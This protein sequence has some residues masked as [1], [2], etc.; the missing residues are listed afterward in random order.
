MTLE[1][2]EILGVTGASGA[3]MSTLIKAIMLL[4][5][6]QAGQVLIKGQHHG[7]ASARAHIAYLPE[8]VR[9]PGHLT[10]HDFIA[11]TRTVQPGEAAPVDIGALATDLDLKPALV[12]LP[13][14][15]YAKDEVQKL[16]LV[17]LLATGRPILLLDRPM[18]DLEPSARAGLRHRLRRHADDG[19][20]VLIGSSCIEDHHDVV[21]RLLM[22][23]EGRLA[24]VEAMEPFG[25]VDAA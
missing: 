19:G 8:T 3:G 11:M 18:S 7:L 16:A 20:A 4:V 5:A 24:D 15:R 22:L 10:G 9:P 23:K 14:R 6:P 25:S 13:I 17:A 12:A 1:A 2:G 21:D